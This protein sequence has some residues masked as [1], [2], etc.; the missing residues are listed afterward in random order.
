LKP[1]DLRRQMRE[2]YRQQ[3]ELTRKLRAAA[4][5]QSEAGPAPA[6]TTAP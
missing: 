2:H 5:Q 1:E 6:Q 3:L 4:P